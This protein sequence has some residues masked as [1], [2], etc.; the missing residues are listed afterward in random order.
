MSPL[1]NKY[2]PDEIRNSVFLPL[3]KKL[4]LG[5]L[6]A[7]AK[8]SPSVVITRYSTPLNV[9]Y[10][11]ETEKYLWIGVRKSFHD[12]AHDENISALPYENISSPPD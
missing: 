2:V 3:I 7:D 4:S 5:A 9:C 12:S 6:G 1:T 10:A 11:P 8:T